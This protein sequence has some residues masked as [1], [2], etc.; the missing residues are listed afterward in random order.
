MQGILDS[1]ECSGSKIGQRVILPASFIGGQYDMKRRHVDAMSL[2][3][4]FGKPNI[5]L[6]MTCNPSWEEI[7]ESQ[8]PT[9]KTQNRPDLEARVFHAKLALLKKND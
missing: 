1:G 2:V 5:F 6:P 4:K 3:Q 9:N 8:L 7:K